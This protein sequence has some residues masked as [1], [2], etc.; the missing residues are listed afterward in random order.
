MIS[1][2]KHVIFIFGLFGYSYSNYFLH[3]TDVHVDPYYDVGSPNNC[4]LGSTGM[5]CCRWD[6]IPKEPFQKAN[7]WGDY[8][9]DATRLLVNST[10]H[11]IIDV[12]N[13]TYDFVLFTGDIIHHHLLSETEHGNIKQ[14]KEFFSIMK[15]Y[16]PKTQIYPCLGNHDTFPIDQLAPP[17]IFSRFLMKYLNETWKL[18]KDALKTLAYGGYYTQLIQPKWRIVAINSLYYDNHNKL[19]KETID[20]ANQFKWLNDTLLE[21]KKNNEVVYFIGHIAPKMGEATDYFTKNFKEIMK[22]YNDTIKY[23]FWGHEHKDR[24]FVYQDAHN[25]TYSFGFV[26]GSL[27]SDHKYPNFRVY[28]YDPKTKDILDFY[29]YRVN[30]TETIRTNKISIDQSYNASHTYGLKTIDTKSFSKLAHLISTNKSYFDLYCKLYYDTPEKYTCGK[31][32]ISE[33]YV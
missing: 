22:E 7:K 29:H 28:K 4:L 19:I 12:L 25:N 10:F 16:F 13:Y 20:I 17:S 15:Y 33:I 23:Q 14:M 5:G 8:N 2:F 27:V 24:F 11:H 32:L 31:E 9:C 30:L 21:A 26:G 6:S 1:Y 3:I 18:D